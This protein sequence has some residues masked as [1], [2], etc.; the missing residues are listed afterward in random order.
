MK[1]GTFRPRFLAW[2]PMAAICCLFPS[3]RKIRCRV[4]YGSLRSASSNA[5]PIVPGMS[6]VIDAD[7]HLSRAFGPGCSLRRAGGAAM[8]S[9]SRAA[10]VTAATATISAIFLI[11]G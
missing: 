11:P 3:T 9:G 4:R 7:T 6:P 10:G 8:S 2:S 1:T 5:V